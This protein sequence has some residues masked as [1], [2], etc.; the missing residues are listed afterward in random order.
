V[1]PC[2]RCSRV[3]GHQTLVLSVPAPRAW[4]S[5]VP[6]CEVYG[7]EAAERLHARLATMS[8]LMQAPD[9]G[10]YWQDW[11]LVGN[12]R[13]HAP[14]GGH[15]TMRSRR[16]RHRAWRMHGRGERR[17][18]EHRREVIGH[19]LSCCLL[20]RDGFAPVTEPVRSVGQSSY[21]RLC[22][23]SPLWVSFGGSRAHR[24]KE[25]YVPHTGV[26][27]FVSL[28]RKKRRRVTTPRARVVVVF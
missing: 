2:P 25:V 14:S 13:L 27:F 26:F 12:R 24:E 10:L 8:N 9:I 11:L 15:S 22:L 6:L 18:Q 21:S 28:Y 19:A 1:P 23:S 16:P 3:G 7:D 20:A 5:H 4:R 17:R